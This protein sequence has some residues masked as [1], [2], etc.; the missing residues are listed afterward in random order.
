LFSGPVLYVKAY[1]KQAI[2]YRYDCR[3]DF[4]IN[5][6]GFCTNNRKSGPTM[7]ESVQTTIQYVSILKHLGMGNYSASQPTK[8]KEN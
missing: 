2:P 7:Y 1:K 3:N 4:A 5:E 8:I 6:G